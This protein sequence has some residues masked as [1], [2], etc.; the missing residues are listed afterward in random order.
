ML[1][2]VKSEQRHGMQISAS[3]ELMAKALDYRARR[4]SLI[5]SNIANID[6]PY[7]RPRDVRFEEA[8]LE[9]QRQIY[10]QPGKTLG[11]A[12]THNNHMEAKKETATDQPQVFIRDGHMARNDGNSVDL[13][14]ETTEMAKNSTMYTAIVNALKKDSAIFRSVL[15]ASAKIQ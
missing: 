8:L 9:K 13:D 11:L 14:T 7:Y 6:T 4:Q 12:T 5:S 15:E 1:F 10:R 2:L 3:H